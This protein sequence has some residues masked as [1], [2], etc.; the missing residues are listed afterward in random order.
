LVIHWFDKMISKKQ[1]QANLQRIMSWFRSFTEIT[2][3]EN[4]IMK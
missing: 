4:N 2:M 3:N 1:N